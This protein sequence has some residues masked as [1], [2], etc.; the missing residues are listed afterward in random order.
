MDGDKE[1]SRMG[2]NVFV[3]KEGHTGVVITNRIFIGRIGDLGREHNSHDN[4]YPSAPF[5][6][7]GVGR[8]TIDSYYFTE[9]DTTRQPFPHWIES[10]YGGRTRSNSLS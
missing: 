9:N 7:P 10:G 2:G 6:T 8:H 5:L 3:R 1:K 4:T